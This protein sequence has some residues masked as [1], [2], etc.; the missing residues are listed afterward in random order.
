MRYGCERS[1]R[2][3]EGRSPEYQVKGRGG[4]YLVKH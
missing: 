4:D 2:E 1:I 3:P